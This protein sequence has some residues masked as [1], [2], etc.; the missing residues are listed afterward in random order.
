MRKYYI[1][2]LFLLC[3]ICNGYQKVLGQVTPTTSKNYVR[4]I[5]M[6]EALTGD[7]AMSALSSQDRIETINYLDA[8]G[9]SSQSVTVKGSPSGKDVVVA[10]KY[11]GAGR[12]NYQYMPYAT[13]NTSGIYNTDPT[14]A[15]TNFYDGTVPGRES[16]DYPYYQTFYEV[17]PLNRVIKVSG[18]DA[19]KTHPSNV[20]YSTNASSVTHWKTN[21]SSY[22]IPANQLFATEYFDEDGHKT[23]EYKNKLGQ[24]IQKSVYNGTTWLNT[25]YVY[26][27]HGLL[28]IVV[29]PKAGGATDTELCYYYTY[30]KRKRITLKDLPGAEPVYMA[31][32][33]RDRLVMVQDGNLDD[34]DKWLA[35][36]Y[37]ALNRPVLTAYTGAG[38]TV[39]DVGTAFN[40]GFVNAIYSTSGT[41]FDYS[42][43][44]PSGFSIS[45][46]SIQSATYYDNYDFIAEFG[47][48][49]DYNTYN[50]GIPTGYS[51]TCSSQCK[52]FTTGT[53][54]RVKDNQV[55]NIS[56]DLLLSVMY[57]DDKGRVCRVVS[58]NHLGGKDVLYTKYNFANQV[59]QTVFRHNVNGSGEV[60]RLKTSYDYDDQGRLKSE[61]DSISGQ[62][63][64]TLASYTYNELGDVITKKLHGDASGNNF[65]QQ[66]DYTYNIK[67]WLRKI[68]NAASLGSDLF[69]LELRYNT[70]GTSDA[71]TSTACYN[72]NISEMLWNNNGTPKGY[73]FSYDDANRI[74]AADYAD[75]S[76]YTSNQNKYNTAYGYDANGNLSSLS[77]YLNGTQIDNLV[78]AYISSGNRL[79][80]VQD[81]SNNALGYDDNNGTYT[82]DANGNMTYD[83]SKGVNISYNE[84]N[85]PEQVQFGANDNN[86]YI[87]DASGRKC[88]KVVDG[89]NAANNTRIDYSENIIYEDNQLK[90][91]FTSE[92]RIVKDGSTYKFEYNMKDHLGNVRVA[93]IGQSSGTPLVTQ[94]S[95]YFPFGMVAE[96][97]NSYSSGILGNKFLYNG[98]ELQD[99]DIAGVKLD[100]YDYGARFY[101]PQIGRFTTVDPMASEREWLSPYNF[102]SLNPISRIDPTGALDDWY[103]TPE[104]EKKYDENIHS[105][106]DMKEK[107]IEGKYL[108]K[109]YKEGDNYYSLFGQVKDLKTMEGKLYEKIDQTLTNYANYIKEYD[110]SAWEEPIERS[111]D[112]N[113]G[114]P[115]KKN[116][117]GFSDYNNYTFSYEGATGYYFVYGDPSAMKGKL[118]WGRDTYS[119][120]KNYG[121]GNMKSGYNTHIYVSKSP[122]LDIVTL[123]FPTLNSKKTLYNKWENEFFPDKK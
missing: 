38:K 84:L 32:D 54:I 122:R 82:Y 41:Y 111:A 114:V 110:P 102:C 68:N 33:S 78:Y 40:N 115:L 79:S 75:G 92:G 8:L 74:T 50:I 76:S 48:G 16:G 53:L 52:G 89:T 71:L 51:T 61:K 80:S 94:R 97:T 119:A 60:V 57:Y 123:V 23:R 26:D 47:T 58:D 21:K 24:I 93:F 3:L 1:I 98:K 109:T 104:G 10:V 25:S 105:A 15:C 100:W 12:Q 37:D 45:E 65:N 121:F 77:R 116:A 113:I 64:I 107:R 20:I 28:S 83:P 39:I 36:I 19:W 108:G 9:R 86:R 88:A 17:S 120:N 44:M 72:G 103:E 96:Q 31:Y 117:F 73:G 99:D 118:E 62:P 63:A 30:D 13:T 27:A 67:G 34:D 29:P 85:L 35:T 101:D 69:A 70:P 42:V 91:I 6:R 4:T 49:Y 81:N 55:D 66:L 22:S 5:I 106:K 59:V 87:Y 11:D 90:A 7:F 43:S 2:H 14:T 46:S 112:F 18:P 95:S 56:N